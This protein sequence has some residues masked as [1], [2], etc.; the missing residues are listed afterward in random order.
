MGSF[1]YSKVEDNPM[2][3]PQGIRDQAVTGRCI[4]IHVASEKLKGISKEGGV[5]SERSLQYIRRLLRAT[6]KQF[7][8]V[9]IRCDILL[10][11]YNRMLRTM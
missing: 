9:K 11:L 4:V 5:V 10:I 1:E 2:R 8:K 7:H 6:G 3:W